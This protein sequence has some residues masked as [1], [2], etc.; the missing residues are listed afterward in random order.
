VKLTNEQMDDL[1]DEW[2]DKND[3]SDFIGFIIL[4]S[5]LNQEQIVHWIETGELPK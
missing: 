3:N 1:V 4:R 5:G 2:H